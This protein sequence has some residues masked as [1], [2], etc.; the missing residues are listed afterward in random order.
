MTPVD[1]LSRSRESVKPVEIPPFPKLPEVWVKRFPEWEKWEE[2]MQQ[3]R[4][5]FQAELQR[6][7]TGVQGTTPQG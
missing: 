1:R 4:Q 3:W 6:S 2:Q 5:S 7:F